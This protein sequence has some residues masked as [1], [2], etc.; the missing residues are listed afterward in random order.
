MKIAF[1]DDTLKDP[2]YECNARDFHRY[3]YNQSVI[4]A[5]GERGHDV[6][7][8]SDLWE[9]ADNIIAPELGFDFVIS[10]L[11]SELVSY[12]KEEAREAIDRYGFILS[13]SK[14]QSKQYS[15]SFN[16]LD[17]IK[18]KSPETKIIIYSGISPD[19]GIFALPH[20]VDYIYAFRFM[21]Y[22]NDGS[23]E[24][25]DFIDGKDFEPAWD[26]N[27]HL[28]EVVEELNKLEKS[29]C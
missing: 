17:K 9:F 8:Y 28:E 6:L 7:K 18:I 13:F 11:P 29:G 20:N 23:Q 22:E 15:R 21:C 2:G 19:V 16:A 1:I 24:I 26:V 14:M 4:S 3:R 12:T 25:A 5:V 27:N 10:N